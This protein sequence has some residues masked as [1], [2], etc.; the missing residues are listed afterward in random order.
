VASAIRLSLHKGHF[1]KLV[2]T[3]DIT[4]GT[5]HMQAGEPFKASDVDGAVILATGQAIIATRADKKRQERKVSAP[6][7]EPEATPRRTRRRNQDPSAA[8]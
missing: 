8:D 5:R 6:A 4:Y 7:A 3:K 2:A 1:M